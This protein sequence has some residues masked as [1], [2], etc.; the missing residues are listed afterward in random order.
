MITQELCFGQVYFR[1]LNEQ[2]IIIIYFK[3]TNRKRDENNRTIQQSKIKTLLQD[4]SP[5]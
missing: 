5:K 2:D 4:F 1:S 3:Q